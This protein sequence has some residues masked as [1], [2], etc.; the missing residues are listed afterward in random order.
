MAKMKTK[1]T[2]K[3][4]DKLYFSKEYSLCH[5][6]MDF[7]EFYYFLKNAGDD[8]SSQAIHQAYAGFQKQGEIDQMRLLRSRVYE[9]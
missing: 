8:I 6:D 3:Q 1:V 5:H 7:E 2:R 9:G 4:A